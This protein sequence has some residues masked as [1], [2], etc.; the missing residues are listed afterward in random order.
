MF[1]DATKLLK[2]KQINL[3]KKYLVITVCSSIF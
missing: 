1:P 2:Q 3:V